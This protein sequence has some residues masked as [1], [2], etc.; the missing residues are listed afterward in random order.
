MAIQPLDDRRNQPIPMAPSPAKVPKRLPAR[1]AVPDGK[2]D[3]VRRSALKKQRS[4]LDAN[5]KRKGR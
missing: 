2:A 4:Q 5:R 1:A 3:I